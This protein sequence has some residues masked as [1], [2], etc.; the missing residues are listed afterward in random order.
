MKNRLLIVFIAMI[1]T[2]NAQFTQKEVKAV[3]SKIGGIFGGVSGNHDKHAETIWI[4]SKP[5]KFTQGFFQLYFGLKKIDGV[6]T[7]LPMRIKV[8]YKANTWIFYD[9]V[10]F[11]YFK[12]KED[13]V[14][15][16]VEYSTSDPIRNNSTFIT[17]VTDEKLSNNVFEF[18]KSASE[19]KRW[20]TIRLTGK[21]YVQFTIYG[22][23]L[24]KSIPRFI[25]VYNLTY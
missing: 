1:F 3:N 12:N 24:K 25:E 21:E 15:S 8:H 2:A 13:D 20:I 4:R 5:I 7:K 11:A 22:K 9:K 16:T 19:S 18:L 23:A 14:L 10:S 6:I 17:E